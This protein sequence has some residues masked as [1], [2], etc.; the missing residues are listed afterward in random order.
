MGGLLS[1]DLGV[2]NHYDVVFLDLK[3]GGGTF[4]EFVIVHV[5]VAEAAEFTIHQIAFLL[6]N[7]MLCDLGLFT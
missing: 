2:V 7:L 6:L 5:V 3:F 1:E 4:S